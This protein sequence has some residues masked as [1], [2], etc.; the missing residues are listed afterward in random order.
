MLGIHIL[1]IN[2]QAFPK[3]TV[4]IVNFVHLFERIVLVFWAKEYDL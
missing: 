1:A 4:R 2:V 3:K